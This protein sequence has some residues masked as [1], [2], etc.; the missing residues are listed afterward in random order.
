M[1][2]PDNG[3]ACLAQ[4]GNTTVF[5]YHQRKASAAIQA[6]EKLGSATVH[7]QR[8]FPMTRRRLILP[9]LHDLSRNAVSKDAATPNHI[10]FA[11]YRVNG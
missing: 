2:E 5:S 6:Q 1:L 3:Y 8:P 4:H 11:M 7:E 10:K 9:K